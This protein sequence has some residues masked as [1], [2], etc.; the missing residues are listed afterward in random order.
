MKI[1]KMEFSSVSFPCKNGQNTCF[2]GW[3]VRQNVHSTQ[4]RPHLE[5]PALAFCHRPEGWPQSH[6]LVQQ[7]LVV[8]QTLLDPPADLPGL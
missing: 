4:L 6:P 5:R 8:F 3:I 2:C 1:C 7:P